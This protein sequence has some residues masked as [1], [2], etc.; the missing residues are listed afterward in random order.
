VQVD[1]ADDSDGRAEQEEDT[2]TSPAGQPAGGQGGLY[3]KKPPGM[4]LSPAPELDKVR[5]KEMEKE[6]KMEKEME[7][8]KEK[9]KENEKVS[10]VTPSLP[11]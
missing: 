8:E 10:S 5:D 1:S 4:G 2:S 3:T 7:K 9:E 6:M 11:S